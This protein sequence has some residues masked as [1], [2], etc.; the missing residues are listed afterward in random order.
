MISCGEISQKFGINLTQSTA[1]LILC[2]YPCKSE[3]VH[4]EEY[5]AIKKLVVDATDETL[6]SLTKSNT[7]KRDN[8][9]YIANNALK[10]KD[11]SVYTDYEFGYQ[12]MKAAGI[13]CV[14][15]PLGIYPPVSGAENLSYHNFLFLMT[16]VKDFT[17]LP[18]HQRVAQFPFEG[19]F[20]RKDLLPLT[21]RTY[22]GC[23]SAGTGASASVGASA[24]SGH[25]LPVWFNPCFD[26][27]TELH[28]FMRELLR[29]HALGLTNNWIFKPSQGSRALGHKVIVGNSFA[30]NNSTN[31][32]ASVCPSGD[33]SSIIGSLLDAVSVSS[34][35]DGVSPLPGLLKEVI[36]QFTDLANYNSKKDAVAQLIISNPLT[37]RGRKFDMRCV[38]FVRSFAPFEGKN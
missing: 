14:L 1:V 32:N 12:S 20:V 19:G 2:Q 7:A 27:S 30:N 10:M 23:P 9:P 29:R 34:L 35:T 6:P 38:V 26:L 13:P 33:S 8:R 31:N 3:W 24:A 16:H 36:R 17:T 37:V 4:P 21:V 5:E 22:C 28:F 15:G 25:Q 18:S 11:I